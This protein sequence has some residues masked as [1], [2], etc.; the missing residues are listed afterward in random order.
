MDSLSRLANKNVNTTGLYEPLKYPPCLL[1][2]NSI[3]NVP[4]S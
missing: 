3:F 2:Y 1:F 4:L